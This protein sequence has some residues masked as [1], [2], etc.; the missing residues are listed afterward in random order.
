MTDTPQ[1]Y[2]ELAYEMDRQRVH[3]LFEMEL[4]HRP[5]RNRTN[6]SGP[7][8]KNAMDCTPHLALSNPTTDTPL[9]MAG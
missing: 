7:S 9:D 5:P 6:Q 2:T 3:M 4:Q 8:L 1:A